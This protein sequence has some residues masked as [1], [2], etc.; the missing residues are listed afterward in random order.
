MWTLRMRL[1]SCFVSL[2]LDGFVAAFCGGGLL[3]RVMGQRS[4]G[5]HFGIIQSFAAMRKCPDS[6]PGGAACSVCSELVQ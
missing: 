6:L 2:E 4:L 3:E 1:R 5:V